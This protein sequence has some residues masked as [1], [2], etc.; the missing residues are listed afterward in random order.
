MREPADPRRSRTLLALV[1]AAFVT[2]GTGAAVARWDEMSL[3]EARAASTAG[4]PAEARV[5][6][7]T[8]GL[9][10]TPER[11]NSCLDGPDGTVCAD[12]SYDPTPRGELP[13]RAGGRLV[14]TT[15]VR[16]ALVRVFVEEP[17]PRP[18][19]YGRARPLDE[20]RRRWRFSLP[21]QLRRGNALRILVEYPRGAGFANFHLGVVLHPT[22][23]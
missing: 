7:T 15:D 18:V 17:G 21:K 23:H 22:C 3:D 20:T 14:I 5:K 1:L 2:G 4:G 10:A 19:Y 6:V 11:G 9:T 16:A 8:R 12:H 13:I